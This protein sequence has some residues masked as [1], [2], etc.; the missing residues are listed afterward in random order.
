MLNFQIYYKKPFQGT[1]LTRLLG[2]FNVVISLQSEIAKQAQTGTGAWI[3][4]FNT[5]FYLML[6][7]A[8]RA[9]GSASSELQLQLA[10]K[11]A[12]SPFTFTIHGVKEI[13]GGKCSVHPLTCNFTI[14][15]SFPP[16]YS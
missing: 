5:H 9:E 3:F 16:S 6:S 8:L 15:Q 7:S 13:R 14:P 2:G 4:F 1:E 11:A 12:H 10:G